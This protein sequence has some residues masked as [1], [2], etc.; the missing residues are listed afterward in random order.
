MLRPSAEGIRGSIW[1]SHS[2]VCVCARARLQTGP[3]S[4]SGGCR[5]Q[6]KPLGWDAPAPDPTPCSS[7]H[8]VVFG[9]GLLCK[10]CSRE[11]RRGGEV[12]DCLFW[13]F[14]G[15]CF[16]ISCDGFCRAI[17]CTVPACCTLGSRGP[18]LAW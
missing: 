18:E 17:P 6:K 5:L 9:V 3:G 2:C 7:V 16:S 11:R 10:G 1:S 15:F 14:W 12:Q 4:M 13:A 8:F